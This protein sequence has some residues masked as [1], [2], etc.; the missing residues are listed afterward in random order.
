MNYVWQ[1]LCRQRNALARLMLGSLPREDSAAR[2][3]APSS[4]DFPE[5]SAAP[6][7]FGAAAPE[8][9]LEMANGVPAAAAAWAAAVPDG[10]WDGAE[11]PLRPTARPDTGTWERA[12]SGSAFGGRAAWPDVARTPGSAGVQPVSRMAELWGGNWSSPAGERTSHWGQVSQ[13]SGVPAA[14]RIAQG[15][16]EA[17]FRETRSAGT[18][19]APQI[20][21]VTELAETPARSSAATPAALSR[22]FE[23]DA[24][25]YDGGFELYP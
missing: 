7:G 18:L 3:A 5:Q 15:E 23:R 25:R 12:G 8:I 24:R 22:A 2:A 1:E 14:E 10:E 17:R 11:Y 9:G 16:T 6:E 21:M 20:R 19:D 4:E 13:E